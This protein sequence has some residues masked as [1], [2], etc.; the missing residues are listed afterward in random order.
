M[1]KFKIGDKI[2]YPN[3]LKWGTITKNI[4]N[5]TH[6]YLC[7]VILESS[8]ARIIPQE[9]LIHAEYDEKYN[10]EPVSTFMSGLRIPDIVGKKGQFRCIVAVGGNEGDYIP[11]FH[12]FNT[13]EDFISC[14]GGAC[15]MF[16]ENKYFNHNKHTGLLTKE[17]LESIVNKLKSERKNGE[18]WWEYLVC[19]WNLEN[20]DTKLPLPENLPMPNYDY[21]TIKRYK[22]E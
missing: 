7:E 16:K 14:H 10:E 20:P 9:D 19:G 15:L 22:E 17:Q 18:T 3:E 11:H 8:S 4:P 5:N 1:K 12:V 6:E 21:K 13:K 2:F